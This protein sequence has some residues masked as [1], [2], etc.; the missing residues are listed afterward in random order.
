MKLTGPRLD[1]RDE[2]L[3]LRRMKILSKQKYS[4]LLG[5]LERQE[6]G[7][8]KRREKAFARAEADRVEKERVRR[9]E[10]AVKAKA[11]AERAKAKRSGIFN[12]SISDDADLNRLWKTIRG[13]TIR[14]LANGIDTILTISDKSYKEFRKDFLEKVLGRGYDAS[15]DVDKLVVVKPSNLS[16]TRILQAFRDGIS[17]CVFEPLIM[18]LETALENTDNKSTSKR[19]KERIN[20]LSNLEKIYDAGVPEDKMEEVARASGYKILIR[21]TFNQ[22]LK[23]YN[24]SGKSIVSFTNTRE[25]H[26]DLGHLVLNEKGEVVSVDE[27]KKLLEEAQKDWSENKRL[28]MVD[29]FKEGVCRKLYTLNGTYRLFDADSDWFEMMNTEIDLKKYSFNATKYPDVNNFIK[30]GRVINSWSL[31]LNDAEPTDHYDMPKAY[32]QFT[33]CHLYS[34]FLGVIHQWRSGSFDLDF[35]KEHIG[36]YKFT[37]LDSV[38]EKYGLFAGSEYTL[39]SVEILYFVSKG[40]RVAITA[41]VWGSRMDFTFPEYMLEKKRYARWSGRLGM[42]NTHKTYTFPCSK[43]WAGHLKCSYDKVFHWGSMASVKIPNTSIITNHHILAFITSYVRIQ[44]MEAIASFEPEM[45]SR[46]VMDGI[47]FRGDRPSSI[48]W[49]VKKDLKKDCHCMYWYSPSTC[50]VDWSPVVYSSNTCLTGQGGS[51]KTFSVLTDMGYNN[52]LFITPQHVLGSDVHEK[53]GNT[54]TTIHKLIGVDCRPWKE[55][56]QY[57]AVLFVDELTQVHG[58]WITKVFE[59]YKDS[60][61]FVAGDINASGQWFQCRGG[62]GKQ[63]NSIWKPTCNVVEIAGDRRSLD[64]ELKE[65]KLRIREYMKSIFVDGDSGEEFLIRNWCLKNCS[66]VDFFTAASMFSPGDSWIAG[67]HRT[68]DSLLQLG[69]V[70]GFYK[71]GGFI[72][73]VP[74][75]GYMKRGSF[76][77]HSYQGK[78]IT[79]GKIFISITDCFEYSMFYTAVSRAVHFDQLVF[80]N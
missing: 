64:N 26:L 72:S 57:P 44:M 16:A 4:E 58:S 43:E 9:L 34:G 50:S 6:S 23:C 1:K 73:S 78:T 27:M 5:K 71:P 79:S 37:L 38:F 70:S 55:E 33:K 39:P 7:V 15:V 53:Y 41:G 17:H 59:M 22:V 80:V 74:V 77:I 13:N 24:D 8:I 56:K 2:Y 20:K 51:G 62:D 31:L 46:V 49:F 76:T 52:I 36:I 19:L 18:K 47:Y 60:L 25:H 63:Y 67:T 14:F 29:D 68:S 75:D 12:G 54:Y 11:R 32:T 10:S 45:V 66:V 35:I 28:Y 61:I 42:E 21:D 3:L 69:V 40:C 30:E 65:F 48:D